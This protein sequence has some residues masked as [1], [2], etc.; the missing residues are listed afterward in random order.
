MANRFR[1][2]TGFYPP[3]EPTL[4]DARFNRAGS[5]HIDDVEGDFDPE[6]RLYARSAGDDKMPV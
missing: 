6:W 2:R 5:G 4:L 3:F 1:K